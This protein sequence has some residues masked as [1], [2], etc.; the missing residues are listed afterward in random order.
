MYSKPL[1]GM[2][3][4]HWVILYNTVLG[5]NNLLI[6]Q[7]SSSF[8]LKTVHQLIKL[9]SNTSDRG[10]VSLNQDIYMMELPFVASSI[11]TTDPRSFGGYNKL[12]LLWVLE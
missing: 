10:A 6:I 4:I 8:S 3:L 5:S 11:R 2:N 9:R 12:P 1:V 7:G